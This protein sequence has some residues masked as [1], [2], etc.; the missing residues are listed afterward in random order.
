MRAL[1]NRIALYPAMLALIAIIIIVV[2][3]AATSTVEFRYASV[4]K[5]REI[6]LGED[7]WYA[8]LGDAEIAIRLESITPDKTVD[9]LK[10][11]YAEQVL[12]WSEEEIAATRKVIAR[13]L[14]RLRVY[15]H[16]LPDTVWLIKTTERVEGGMPHTRNN[17]IVLPTPGNALDDNLL[18][19]EL[20]HVLSRHQSGD[21]ASLYRILGFK[22]CMLEETPWMIS[23]RLSNPD[24]P[25]GAYYVDREGER[26]RGILPWVHT[27]SAAFDPTVTSGLGGH[28]RFAFLSV[29]IEGENCKPRTPGRDIPWELAPGQAPEYF[30][31]IGDNTGYIIHPEEVLADNF[32]F[33]VTGREDLPS[34]EIVED[35]GNWLASR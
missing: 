27:S 19:H 6:L 18:L 8:H 32:V 7:E 14:P 33:L 4:E 35:L 1:V 16:L 17:A 34:P 28:I 23:R 26:P 21:Q 9:D 25:F 5:G 24:V 12:A 10:K 2:R 22:P 13:N 31:A 15:D 30:A 20:F 11:L 3:C 29:E